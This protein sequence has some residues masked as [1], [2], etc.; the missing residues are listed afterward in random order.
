MSGGR[1][2]VIALEGIPEIRPGDDL[3]SMLIDAI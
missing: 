1:L 2:S 3:E